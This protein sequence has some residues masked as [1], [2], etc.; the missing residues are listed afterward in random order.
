MYA[1]IHTY[2][3]YLGQIWEDGNSIGKIIFA[4]EF[5]Y[6]CILNVTQLSDCVLLILRFPQ[7]VV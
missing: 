7:N 4:Q 2:I 3:L 1:Y 6:K 5:I